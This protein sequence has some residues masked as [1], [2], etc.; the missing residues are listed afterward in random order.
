[1][2]IYREG[3]RLHEAVANAVFYGTCRCSFKARCYLYGK[4]ERG[5]WRELLPLGRSTMRPLAVKFCY[6]EIEHL[7]RS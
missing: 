1:M 6:R 7:A 5:G 3:A 4:F 2:T